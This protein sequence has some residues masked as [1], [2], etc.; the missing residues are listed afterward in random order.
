MACVRE[1]I[2]CSHFLKTHR[3]SLCSNSAP[4][5]GLRDNQS[6]YSF[7]EIIEHRILA[8]FYYKIPQYF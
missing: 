2:D 5:I 4:V 7:L 8:L 3:V 6:E 1:A